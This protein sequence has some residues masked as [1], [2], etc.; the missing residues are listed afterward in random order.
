MYSLFTMVLNFVHQDCQLFGGMRNINGVWKH[1]H[2]NT[3]YEPNVVKAF[4]TLVK[5]KSIVVDIGANVG[6]YSIIS[7]LLGAQV[8]SVEMQPVCLNVMK[9]LVD[10]N[11]VH[12]RIRILDGFISTSKRKIMVPTDDCEPMGSPEAVAGRWPVGV[13]RKKNYHLDESRLQ[14]VYHVNLARHI[15]RPVDLLKIDTEG[16]EI[17]VLVSLKQKWSFFK[18]VIIEFQPGAWTFHN[19]SKQYGI[20]V[21]RKFIKPYNSIIHLGHKKKYARKLKSMEFIN[22]IQTQNLHSFEEFLFTK[23]F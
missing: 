2:W 22:F 14:Q 3:P 11:N 17:D 23:T 15:V 12:D 21:L 10:L 19:I 6:G 4:N 18:S 7:A 1:P 5:N 8:V 20:H 16:C 9:C 13:L